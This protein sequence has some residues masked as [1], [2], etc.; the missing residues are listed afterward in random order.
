MCLILFAY[1]VN[2]NYKFILAANRDEFYERPTASAHFWEDAPEI[3]AGR[4]LALGGTWLGVT[5]SG[6]FSAVTNYRNPNQ[7]QGKL[8]RG[9]LVSDFLGGDDSVLDYLKKVENNAEDYTGFNL[10]V[11]D[12][13]KE[14]DELAYF[15]NRGKGIKFFEPGIYGLSNHL[16]DTPWQ[17]VVLG[18]EN[19]EK[20]ISKQDFSIDLVFKIL[21]DKTIAPV[22]DL[23]ETG[24]GIEKERILSPCFIET[25]IY[26]T[27][28]SAVLL[29]GKNGLI[30]FSEQSYHPPIERITE[31]FQID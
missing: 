8:S 3:L 6:R 23:P 30:N 25:P 24:V 28:S 27:R 4:D 2:P 21:K 14:N 15:S 20:I 12:F 11:G 17:K 5:K 13:G 26:G 16:I 22:E 9:A 29:V 18:K 10:L 1:K 7:P 31:S 19:L